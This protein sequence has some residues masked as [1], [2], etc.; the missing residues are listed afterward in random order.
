MLIPIELSTFTVDPSTN[1]P[2]IVLRE[3]FGERTLSIAVGHS[4]ANA[5][6]LKT[7]DVTAEN[8]HTI[9]LVAMMME[10]LGGSLDKAVLMPGEEKGTCAA[11]LFV[12]G[13]KGVNILQCRPPDAI[14]LAIR[15]QCPVFA[16]EMLLIQAED[17]IPDDQRLRRL[18]RSTDTLD[19]GRY[20]LE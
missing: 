20:Y 14:S 5:I 4:D 11:R 10:G 16:D 1:A 7:M 6:A 15:A 2:V 8:P 19:F 13:D 3:L 17:D 12:R 18:I 9:D